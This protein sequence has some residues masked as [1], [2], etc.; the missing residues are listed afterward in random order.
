M[1]RG[2][3]MASSWLSSLGLLPI[4]TARDEGARMWGAIYRT[5]SRSPPTLCSRWRRPDAS[6][7]RR[8]CRRLEIER[9]RSL[10]QT[11]VDG[12]L[13]FERPLERVH[14]LE[15]LEHGGPRPQRA[16]HGNLDVFGILRRRDQR[17]ILHRRMGVQLH[18]V[19]AVFDRALDAVAR[20]GVRLLAEELEDPLDAID[21][22]LGLFEVR[23]ERRLEVVRRS[24]IAQL[25]QR[26][27][28]PPL[29]VI[30]AT[31]LL[32]EEISEILD[33]GH[34]VLLSPACLQE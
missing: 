29:R 15:L 17:R 26:L 1:L 6:P 7:L 13:L 30:G 22:R 25:R 3:L 27:H 28:E 4:V 12:L 31:Q 5:G 23:L 14:G 9:F 19:L 2:L 34:G 33:V 8:D 21:V 18:R 20:I 32:E 10:R 24:G 11:L 16:V